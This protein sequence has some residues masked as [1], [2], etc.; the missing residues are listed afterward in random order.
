MARRRLPV[1]LTQAELEA[2]LKA[3]VTEAR[4]A[5]TPTKKRA[6]QRDLVMIETARYAGMRVSELCACRLENVDLAGRTISVIDGKGGKDRNLPI[7]KKLLPILRE[8]IGARAGG[9]LFPS[10]GEKQL[11]ERTVHR[12][13]ALLGAKAG[14]RRAVH[15]HLMRHVFATTLLKTGSDL[16]DVQE[17]MG[18][19]SLQT[20]AIYLHTDV[21]RLNDNVDRL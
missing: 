16:R 14:I 18:H 17:L 7:G 4:Y 21:S 12:R 3:A 6:A 15:P 11:A 10:C 20:T 9:F 2:L 19:A 1:I 13:I 5:G 8:W